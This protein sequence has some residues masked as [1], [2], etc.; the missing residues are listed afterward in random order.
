MFSART[1][2]LLALICSAIAVLSTT[3]PASAGAFNVKPIRIFLSK[4]TGSTILTIENQASE[5]LRL[6]VRAFAWTNDRRGQPVLTPSDDLIVFPTLVDVLP[7]QQ[8]SIRI[9]FSG[10]AAGKELTY[11][12]ALDELPSLQSQLSRSKTPGLEVRTRITVP[13]F[14]TP[15]ISTEKAQID[16]LAIRRG[17]VQA[18]FSN[19]GNVHATV[20]NAEII[21]RDSAGAKVV[22]KRINGW[23]VLAGESWQFGTTVA[24]QCSR[25]KSVSVTVQSD[26]G[27]FTRTAD[28]SAIGCK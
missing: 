16:Q 10:T 11:R 28:A 12:I 25:I 24:S 7:M 3:A 19:V 20:S 21:G 26:I 15:L 4:D 17:I 5:I 1:K 9:G 14:F 18:S 13:V 2:Y 8:R 6:Q 22:D 23:Y 27:R